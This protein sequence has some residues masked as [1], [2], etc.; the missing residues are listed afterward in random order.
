[1]PDRFGEKERA[2]VGGPGH[3]WQETLLEWC[4]QRSSKR[5]RMQKTES[6]R[7]PY[8]TFRIR[9]KWTKNCNAFYL[10]ETELEALEVI[11]GAERKPGLERRR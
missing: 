11:R 10:P 2:R 6:S 7:I 4:T 1:M 8:R 3:I 9:E 5:L